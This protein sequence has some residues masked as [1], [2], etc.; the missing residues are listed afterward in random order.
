MAPGTTRF[1]HLWITTKTAR[2]SVRALPA[3]TY[4]FRSRM[5][6]PATGVTTGWSP[7]LTVTVP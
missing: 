1:A 7:A 2:S 5:R 3:G 4:K 6:N